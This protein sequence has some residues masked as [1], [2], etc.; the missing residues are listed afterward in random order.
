MR[1]HMFG[2]EM[3][4]P[5]CTCRFLLIAQVILALQ[6]PVT[7]VPLI[8]ATSSSRLMGPYRSSVCVTAT[9]WA[10]T[11]LIFSANLVLCINELMPQVKAGAGEAGGPPA[12][13][14]A[15][16]PATMPATVLARMLA[17]MPA[18]MPAM[19]LFSQG[20]QLGH[21]DSDYDMGCILGPQFELTFHGGV[22]WIILQTTPSNFWIP[23]GLA[24]HQL[25]FGVVSVVHLSTQETQ[26]AGLFRAA[27]L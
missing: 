4:G 25:S 7:L 18:V 6:L 22:Q 12:T 14:Q 2:R 24:R 23:T 11:A 27:M 8:K 9:C 19:M 20:V 17:T 10:A 5:V 13:D 21:T 1:Q 26:V 15:M 16:M 3:V